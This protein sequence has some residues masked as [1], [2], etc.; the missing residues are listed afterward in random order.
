MKRHC[1]RHPGRHEIRL[2]CAPTAFCMA[3]IFDISDEDQANAREGSFLERTTLKTASLIDPD[4]GTP[5]WR[6]FS[7]LT[8]HVQHRQSERSD[9]IWPVVHWKSGVRVYDIRDPANAKKIAYFTRHPSGPPD[10]PGSAA[11]PVLDASNGILYT[12]L[13]R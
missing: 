9:N 10:P 5:G 4:L 3:R 8:R 7:P 11:I 2:C 1:P 12:I 6:V 13:H